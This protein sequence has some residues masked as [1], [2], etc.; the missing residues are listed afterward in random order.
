M[1]LVST[2]DQTVRIGEEEFVFRRGEVLTT[3]Y[4]HKYTLDS[5]AALAEA[6]RQGKNKLT[7]VCSPRL[8][9]F[10]VWIE[11]LI[12]ESTGKEGHGILPV[13]GEELEEDLDQPEEQDKEDRPTQGARLFD[14]PP[15]IPQSECAGLTLWERYGSDD[16]AGCAEQ[17]FD[18]RGP[19]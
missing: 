12:A 10:G 7:L 9:P 3:E 17:R 5:F 18:P 19:I 15:E 16:F 14:Q 8:N 2:A 1:Q 11:Q 4:S 13:V 6:A